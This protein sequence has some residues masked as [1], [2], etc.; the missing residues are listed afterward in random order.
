LEKQSVKVDLDQLTVIALHFEASSD[1][2]IRVGIHPEGKRRPVASGSIIV[3][4][5]EDLNDFLGLRV[6]RQNWTVVLQKSRRIVIDILHDDRQRSRRGFRWYPV[7]DRQDFNLRQR[8]I[9]LCLLFYI[10][11]ASALF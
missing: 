10:S 2:V 3:V 9:A 6:F 7:V 1:N 5:S 11:M 4:G 8:A